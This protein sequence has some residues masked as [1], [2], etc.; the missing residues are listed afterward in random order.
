MSRAGAGPMAAMAWGAVGVLCFSGTAPATRVAVPD[1]GPATLTFSRIVIAAVLGAA[2]LALMRRLRF[3]DRSHLPGLVRMGLGLAVGFPLLLALAVDRVPASHGAVVIGLVPAATAVLS[4]L[5]T[6]ER[7]R[8]LFWIGCVTGLA[9]VVAFTISQGGDTVH[10]ADLWLLAAV[11]SCAIGYVEGGRVA[12]ALGAIPTLCWAMILLAP[13]ASA[14]LAIAFVAHPPSAP[15]AGAW[16]GLF[17]AGIFSMFVG[18][19]AWYRGLAI[20]GIARIGQLNL[21]QPLLAIGWSALLLK[22]HITTAVPLTAFVV[23]AAM[24][25][26][27]KS[28]DTPTTT[29]GAGSRG[30]VAAPWER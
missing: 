20:G 5:R 3:P 15:S 16:T 17:Y 12:G 21:A 2:A 7:P 10:L 8:P 27:V 24:A 22:E 1:F 4:V 29:T 9:A 23:I 14:G 28:R 18:S 11:V 13:F 6:D 26:C 19:I 25:L 30:E